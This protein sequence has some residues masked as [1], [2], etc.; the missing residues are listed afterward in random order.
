MLSFYKTYY[1][2][3]F[4]SIWI[5]DLF[6]RIPNTEYN[7]SQIAFDSKTS[8]KKDLIDYLIAYNRKELK[9]WIKI[10]H[11]HDFTPCK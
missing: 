8:F 9:E 11:Q 7:D 1:L 10:I 3:L 6:T 2:F 5:S 4:H